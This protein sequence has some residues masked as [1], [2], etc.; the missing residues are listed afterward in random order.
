MSFLLVGNAPSRGFCERQT[1][2]RGRGGGRVLRKGNPI[3]KQDG[4]SIQ[5]LPPGQRNVAYESSSYNNICRL[6]TM[7]PDM[8][9]RTSST[10]FCYC[11]SCLWSLPSKGQVVKEGSLIHQYCSTRC[12]KDSLMSAARWM[13]LD[14]FTSFCLHAGGLADTSIVRLA[15]RDSEYV[16]SRVLSSASRGDGKPV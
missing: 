6:L 11:E 4:A 7:A 14:P 13:M 2:G 3:T 10:A 8:I 15:S 9:D 12:W 5:T 1:E 16:S